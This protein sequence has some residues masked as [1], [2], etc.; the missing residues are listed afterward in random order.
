MHNDPARS[1]P[2]DR[3]RTRLA[4][5]SRVLLLTMIMAGLGLG[6]ATG[7]GAGGSPGS[8]RGSDAQTMQV[9]VF[10]NNDALAS[11]PTDCSAVFPRERTVPRTA[12]VA[13][14]ALQMLFAG[15]TTVERVG[16]YDS[17]FSSATADLLRRV[18]VRDGTAYVD[19]HDQRDRLAGA[20][21]SCGGA[22]LHSQI[23]HTLRQ[24]PSIDRVRLAIDGDP[25]R[26]YDWIGLGCGPHDARCDPRPFALP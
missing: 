8:G 10:F 6:C 14:A 2:W 5:A 21:S 16:G 9:L 24:F 25:H 3:A 15:P 4:V 7:G 22:A 19:L 18:Q 20:S 11:D 17:F 1:T 12:A 23:E 26:F 13:S